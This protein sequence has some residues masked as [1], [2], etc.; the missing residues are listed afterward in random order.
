MDSLNYKGP[1]VAMTDC[2]VLK[3]GLQYSTHLGCIVGTT[4]DQNECKI[5]NYDDIYHKISYIKQKNAIA[6]YV[7]IYIL[8][9][10]KVS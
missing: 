8:Q 9:V 5:E 10:L 3:A 6:K 1:V 7:R 4:L 2:T